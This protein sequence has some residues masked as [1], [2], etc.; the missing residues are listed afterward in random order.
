MTK[1]LILTAF[2]IATMFGCAV[3]KKKTTSE[4]KTVET[5]K[6]TIDSSSS[7]KTEIKTAETKTIDSTTTTTKVAVKFKPEVDPVTNQIKPFKMDIKKDGKPTTTLEINGNGEVIYS[8]EV[9]GTISSVEKTKDSTAI[10]NVAL[11][12]EIASER[13]K[14]I[15]SEQTI[16][17]SSTA[18]WK[19]WLWIIILIVA[20][21]ISLYFNFKSKIP[22]L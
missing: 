18:I 9:V 16:K 1:K 5:V 13:K 7:K 6:E 2:C 21:V 20:L 15:E 22:F 12:K 10:E 11:K 8:N 14:N 4:E 3:S 17:E 19:L